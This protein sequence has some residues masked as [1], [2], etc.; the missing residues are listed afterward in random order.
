MM[1]L[2]DLDGWKDAINKELSHPRFEGGYVRIHDGGD[3]FSDEYLE[4]WLDIARANPKT[5]FYSYT[6][7]VVRFRKIV[8]T[9]CPPNF[10]YVFS[11]GGK[12]DHLVT[13]ADRQCD[14]FPDEESLE[15]AGFANQ[16]ASDLLAITGDTKV[17]IVINNHRGAVKAMKGLSLREQQAKLRKGNPNAD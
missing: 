15:Q 3:F 11:F 8:E 5:T 2:E 10:Q 1:V 17:G 4:A 9:N 14:V 16:E 12:Y 7:E 13:E 6:K